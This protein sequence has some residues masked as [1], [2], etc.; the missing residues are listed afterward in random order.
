MTLNYPFGLY[1][2]GMHDWILDEL[3]LGERVAHALD[4]EA[5]GFGPLVDLQL[6][7]YLLREE[8]NGV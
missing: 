8:G 2:N 5:C 1:T 7:E 3:E 4:A 6:T